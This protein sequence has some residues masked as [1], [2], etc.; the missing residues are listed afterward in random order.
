M[1]LS[2]LLYPDSD[3]DSASE[4]AIDE[5]IDGAIDGAL[6]PRPLTVSTETSDSLSS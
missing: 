1:D 4:W 2:S 3:S 6:E 5:D